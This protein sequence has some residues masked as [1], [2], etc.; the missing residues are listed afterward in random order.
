MIPHAPVSAKLRRSIKQDSTIVKEFT[1]GACEN[2]K[3]FTLLHHKY[4]ELTEFLASETARIG[5]MN[6]IQ[7]NGKVGSNTM[8]SGVYA[9]PYK[10]G[11][12]LGSTTG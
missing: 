11:E 4:T 7:R 1:K 10:G 12:T 2:R 3:H 5:A 8:I 6:E 9:V